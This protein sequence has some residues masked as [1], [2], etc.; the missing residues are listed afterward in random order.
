MPHF[1]Q[2]TP[3]ML[4]ADLARTI[5]FYTGKLGFY[6]DMCWPDKQP[7][8]CILKRS[9]VS[10]GFFTPDEHRHGQPCGN[11]LFIDVEDVQKLHSE[12]KTKVDMDWGPEVYF[13]GRRE[14]AVR[15][16]DGYLVIFSEP[17][18]DPP[19]CGEV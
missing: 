13:Y 6:L 8:F 9:Q 2:I 17:T 15:D 7:I 14:F 5:D 3:R 16:P 4:V 10:I 19:T 12:L 11:E 18:D 1:Q